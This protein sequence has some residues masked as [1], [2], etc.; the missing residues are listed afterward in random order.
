MAW[1]RSGEGVFVEDLVAHQRRSAS[2]P[3]PGLLAVAVSPGGRMAA[4]SFGQAKTAAND[5]TI[6]VAVV[7]QSAADRSVE[8][9]SR[10]VAQPVD[11]RMSATLSGLTRLGE[12]L[13]TG[14]SH[15]L[16]EIFDLRHKRSTMSFF[17]EGA[18]DF[19]RIQ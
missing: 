10:F 1:G 9:L 11:G 15:G 4:W 7:V 3:V 5:R 13:A 18:L 17:N 12:Q 19:H 2:G 6:S 14:V 8:N 16:L